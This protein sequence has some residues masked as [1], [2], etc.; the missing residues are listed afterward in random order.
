LV[1]DLSGL[2]A[3][4]ASPTRGVINVFP[5]MGTIWSLVFHSARDVGSWLTVCAT[6]LSIFALIKGRLD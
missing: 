5:K 3:S 1:N 2:D 4:L 6:A